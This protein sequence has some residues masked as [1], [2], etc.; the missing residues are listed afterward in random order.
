MPCRDSSSSL[1][2]RLDS[3]GHLVKFDFAK[4]TCSRSIDG[5]T[6]LSGFCKGKTPQEILDLDFGLLVPVLGLK[7]D[8]ERQFILYMEL[9]ALKAAIVQFLG[10]EHKNVDMERCKMSSVEQTEEFTDIVIV[11]LPP[12]EMPNI[13][14]CA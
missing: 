8:E 5:A 11:V 13:P 3:Q 6:G 1:N 12:K 10:I 4:I 7:T 14:P 2:M 9:D